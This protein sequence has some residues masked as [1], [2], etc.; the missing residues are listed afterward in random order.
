MGIKGLSKLV[1]DY[2]PAA[3]KGQK[4]DSYFGR[5]VRRGDAAAAAGAASGERDAR[6]ARYGQSDRGTHSER[7]TR[8]KGRESRPRWRS[9]GSRFASSVLTPELCS[10]RRVG[11]HAT[12]AAAPAPPRHARS[13]Q[14]AVDASMHIYQFMVVVGREGT[15]TLTNEA[16]EVTAHIQ[17][18]LTRT[19]RMLEAGIKPVF[20][21]DGKPPEAKA[22]ELAKRREKREEANK[23]LKAAIEAGDQE[24]I[25][26]MS[27]RTIRVTKQHNEDCK[28]LL[29]L[30]GVPVWDAPSEAEAE[31]AALA[32][33]NV[34][35]AVA[36]EDMD[37]LTQGAPKLTR[38][39][40]SP[41]SS[42]QA[43]D[44]KPEVS[45]FCLPDIL[46]SLEITMDQFI[47]LCILM[48]C[49]YAPTIR[50]LGPVSALKL[51]KQYSSTNTPID[52]ILK[53]RSASRSS[54]GLHRA[55]GPCIHT[56][57]RGRA[58]TSRP[59]R[60]RARNA[61]QVIDRERYPVPEGY[62]EIVKEARRL[63]K[64]PEVTQPG[65][66]PTFKWTDPDEDGL[67]KFLV[68]EKQFNEDRVRSIIARIKK[69][70]GKSKQNRLEAFFGA[71]TSHKSTVGPKKEEKKGKRIGKFAA[72]AASKAKK[73]AKK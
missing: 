33:A 43:K 73:K 11:A 48:G 4:F 31:G 44:G 55:A 41:Q 39:M 28:I 35:Y 64:A 3:V 67:I 36:T 53:V 23:E 8:S 15:Q 54:R 10:A 5:K 66:M 46:S 58:P 57:A 59:L 47:D 16:G 21:F 7:G 30:M 51:I 9:A 29:R 68:K 6:R 62:E 18:M 61:R 52:E 40:F 63:F 34:V 17:G 71:A 32:A 49:D 19:T 50:N 42:K 26:Q 24:K 38:H 37:A 65:D 12:M 13:R 56:D 45:E 70:K 2:A 72:F 1:S 69:A 25:E 14:V 27:K 60:A 20:V 22:D